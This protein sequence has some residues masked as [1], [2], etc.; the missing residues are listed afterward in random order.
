M[1]SGF[2]ILLLV[3][4][5]RLAELVHARRNT[6]ALLALGGRELAPGHYPLIVG[7]HALWLGGLWL[8][9]L[10]KQPDV[11]W[12]AV[13]AILQ[14]TRLWVLATLGRRWTTRIIV[15]PGETLV[16]NGPYRFMAHPNYAVVVGEI[17][18]L[19]LVFGLWRYALVFSVLNALVLAIRVRA[20]N[21]ALS[22]VDELSRQAP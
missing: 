10:N 9:A 22:Q 18:V 1:M 3:T 17:A 14:A 11:A 21:A 5:E 16:R 15:V 7:L 8:L 12:L 6:S 13:F 2:W 20:E 4:G 19:P